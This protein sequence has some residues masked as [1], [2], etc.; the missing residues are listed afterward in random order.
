MSQPSP[1]PEVPP[2]PRRRT[3][4]PDAP[5]GRDRLRHAFRWRWSRG[6]AV[7]AVLLGVLGFAAVAQINATDQD[8]VFEGARQSDLIVLINTLSLATDRAEAEI[9]AIGRA[10]V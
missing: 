5:T 2:A 3:G 10:H 1:S 4:E 9:A 6:Q 8:D 7:A